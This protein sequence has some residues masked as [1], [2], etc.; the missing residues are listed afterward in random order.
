MWLVG[1]MQQLGPKLVHCYKPSHVLENL[2]KLITRAWLM[3]LQI[4]MLHYFV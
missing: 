2:T 4:L 1:K 3:E